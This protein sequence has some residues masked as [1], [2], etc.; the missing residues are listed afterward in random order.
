MHARVAVSRGVT[1]H[2]VVCSMQPG[3]HASCTHDEVHRG[4]HSRKHNQAKTKIALQLSL[5]TRSHAGGAQGLANS[6]LKY[7]KTRR[8]T[9]LVCFLCG[10]AIF[11]DDYAN[12]LIVGGTFRPIM[13]TLFIS[14]EKLAFLVDATAAPVASIA[15]ISSWIGVNSTV[16]CSCICP[17]RSLSHC[18]SFHPP[19]ASGYRSVEP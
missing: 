18:I 4:M 6:I 7:A 14:R 15:P 8:L 9:M 12:S 11:F 2:I 16:N 3:S 17:L 1:M 13:D 19:L 5:A 10:I